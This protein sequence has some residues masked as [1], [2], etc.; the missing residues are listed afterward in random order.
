MDRTSYRNTK[1]L[2]QVA[3]RSLVTS[4]EESSEHETS[5]SLSYPNTPKRLPCNPNYSIL[6]HR[7]AI[8]RGGDVNWSISVHQIIINALRPT[9]LIVF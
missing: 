7:S 6:Y 9:G 8:L 4:R 1:T 3:I 5:L 2:Q